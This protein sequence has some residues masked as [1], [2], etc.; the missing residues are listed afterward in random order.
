MKVTFVLPNIPRRPSGGPRVVYQYANGLAA[1]GHEVTVLHLRSLFG[2]VTNQRLDQRVWQNLKAAAKLVL[3]GWRTRRVSIEWEAIDPRVRL[4]SIPMA[5]RAYIPRADVFVAT[6]WRTAELARHYPRDRGRHFYLVQHYETWNGPAR[7]VDATW[8]APFT[9]IVVSKWLL[10]VGKNLGASNLH[11]I[12]NAIDHDRFYLT[13]PLSGR[14]PRVAMLY[15][16]L[17]WKGSPDGIEAL[18]AAKRSFP[19]LQARLFGVTPR[20]AQLP[21][22]IEYVE[23]PPQGKLREEVYNGSSIYLCPSWTEGWGL[24]IS[25]AMACGCAVVS[26]KNGGV[27]DFVIDG[28]SGLIAPV[29]DVHALASAIERLARDQEECERLAAAGLEAIKSFTYERSLDQFEALLV[30][31]ENGAP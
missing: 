20:P 6:F 18:V 19:T 7:R 5:L 17:D 24:P 8:R 14:T 27:D 28:V 25:E 29:R 16:D 13:R 30:S 3:G 9:K 10:D 26:T 31:G 4:L 11:Y 15:S 2:G 21:A 12:P 23:N 1:R 22:W